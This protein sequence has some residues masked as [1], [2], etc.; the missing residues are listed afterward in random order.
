MSDALCHNCRITYRRPVY[1]AQCAAPL[2]EGQTLEERAPPGPVD[3]TAAILALCQ[4]MT[5][6]ASSHRVYER[7]RA[8]GWELRRA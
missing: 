3:N 4:A 1:C 5:K 8:A 7:L 2:G 6:N